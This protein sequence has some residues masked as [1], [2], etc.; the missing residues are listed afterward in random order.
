MVKGGGGDWLQLEGTLANPYYG[1]TMLRCGE[2]VHTLP[3]EGHVEG[4]P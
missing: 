4:E 1:A 3:A 2:L